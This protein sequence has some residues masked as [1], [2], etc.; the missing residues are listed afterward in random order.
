MRL[1]A[2]LIEGDRHYSW[3]KCLNI[4][5]GGIFLVQKSPNR[6]A[7]AKTQESASAAAG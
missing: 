3:F 5:C 1:D 2:E 6:K 7:E 4:D